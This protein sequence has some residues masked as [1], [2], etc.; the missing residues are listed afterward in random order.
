MPVF[1][2]PLTF[3]SV[4][5]ELPDTQI[6]LSISDMVAIVVEHIRLFL[7]HPEFFSGLPHA[8]SSALLGNL[9]VFMEAE[10][11]AK[12]KKTD[13]IL[14]LPSGVEHKRVDDIS[15]LGV[16]IRSSVAP[17][18]SHTLPFNTQAGR[19]LS[20]ESCILERSISI[21]LSQRSIPASFRA[22]D[23]LYVWFAAM[24]PILQLEFGCRQVQLM[25]LRMIS[26]KE[27]FLFEPVA[28]NP[29]LIGVKAVTIP[30]FQYGEPDPV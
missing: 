25:P 21:L 8:Q 3:V 23:A 29:L 10:K 14:V 16:S 15:S 19:I 24:L 1:S 13:W 5:T 7:S 20:K 27:R 30:S 22:A 26:E 2:Q 4:R 28:G 9:E 18:A 17:N 6:P 11:L 12:S